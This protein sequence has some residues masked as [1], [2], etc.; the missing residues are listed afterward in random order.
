M[1]ADIA[2]I[3]TLCRDH[4]LYLIEDCAHALGA[5]YQ[6]RPCGSFGDIALLSFGRDK[7]ISSVNGGVLL[8]NNP[9]LPAPDMDLKMSDRA[10]IAKNLAYNILGYLARITYRIGL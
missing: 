9:H 10:L 3:H 8:I 7:V 2:A 6:G 5:S 4:K 1:P